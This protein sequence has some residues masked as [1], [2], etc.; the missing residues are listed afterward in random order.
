MTKQ[1]KEF[2][3]SNRK[4]ITLKYKGKRLNAASQWNKLR[5]PVFMMLRGILHSV[6]KKLPAGPLAGGRS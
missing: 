4:G 3:R 2:M 5:N 6:Y 1:I